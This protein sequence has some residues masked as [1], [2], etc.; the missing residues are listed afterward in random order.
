MARPAR[1]E[2]SRAGLWGG[3]GIVAGR[4]GGLFVLALFA[5]LVTSFLPQRALSYLAGPRRLVQYIL[6]PVSD[7]V[8][9]VVSRLR[10]AV[11]KPDDAQIAHLKAEIEKFKELYFKSLAA[12]DEKQRLIEALQQSAAIADGP[13]RPLHAAVI[14]ISSSGVGGTFQVRAGSRHGVER[15]T[16]ASTGGVQLVGRISDVGPRIST[17]T[18]LTDRNAGTIDGVILADD[19]TRQAEIRNLRPLRDKRLLSGQV[20]YTSPPA[21]DPKVGDTVR[22]DDSAWPR[23]A[24]R[25]IIGQV[26]EVQT[27]VGGRIV[28]T[29]K[30][31]VELERLGEVV[32]L[33]S[34]ASPDGVGGGGGTP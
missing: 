31:T 9:A 8:R 16:I 10:P 1:Q 19:G 15:S 23:A 6:Y 29:V 27:I 24:Q 2:S 32:L 5:T 17:V 12:I 28:V 7:P 4:G 30:P 34:P 22:V 33:L 26:V 13:I 20:H 25:L 14:A 21:P 3:G 18:L 11:P